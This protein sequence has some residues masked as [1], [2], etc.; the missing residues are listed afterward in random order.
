MPYSKLCTSGP[1][2]RETTPSGTLPSSGSGT[3]PSVS[4]P[5]LGETSTNMYNERI[6]PPAWLP[7]QSISA[8]FP[9]IVISCM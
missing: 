1:L 4:S 7:G 8:I 6:H 5:K 2:L 3:L 9:R